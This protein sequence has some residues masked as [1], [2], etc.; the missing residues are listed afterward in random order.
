M[1]LPFSNSEH[2]ADSPDLNADG[3][4]LNLIRANLR[5]TPL[6]RVRRNAARV[7]I[8]RKL[9]AVQL[10]ADEQNRAA[11]YSYGSA[12]PPMPQGS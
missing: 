4:D 11:S 6:E 3:I 1:N 8:L 5:L 7:R 2:F 9:H 12:L 10:A